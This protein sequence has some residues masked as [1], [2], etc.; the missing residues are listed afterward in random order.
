[1]LV[2]YVSIESCSSGF[3]EYDTI[4]DN[5]E[6]SMDD[7]DIINA[8]TGEIYELTGKYFEESKVP[9]WVEDITG[10]IHNEPDYVFFCR[11][12]AGDSYFGLDE[13]AE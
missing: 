5:S 2:K 12:S 9:D 4:R 6:E 13:V 10:R 7:A 1:M 3:G 8:T 11:T